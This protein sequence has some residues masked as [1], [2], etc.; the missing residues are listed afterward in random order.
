[1]ITDRF[2]VPSRLK[3]AGLI[4]TAIGIITVIAGAISFFGGSAGD[5]H[6]ESNVAR[7]WVALLHNSVFFLMMA[8]ASIFILAATS[9]AQGAW[10]VAYRRVPEAIG[11]NVWVFG[12]IALVIL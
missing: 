8:V 3:N 5:H 10:I 7:F 6:A 1:M 2:V 12:V 11:A 9:L 4:F